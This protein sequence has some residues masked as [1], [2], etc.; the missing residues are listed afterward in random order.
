VSEDAISR[1]SQA[2]TGKPYIVSLSGLSLADNLEMLTTVFQTPGVSAIELNLACP[3]IPGKPTVAYDFEQMEAVLDAVTSLPCFGTVP[4]GVKLAP[5]F[6][7]PHVQRAAKLVARHPGISFIVSVNTVSDER[8][9][10][11]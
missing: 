6:D 5:Y 1:L 10:D 2:A 11:E 9:G 3:N 4:F 8:R 7:V